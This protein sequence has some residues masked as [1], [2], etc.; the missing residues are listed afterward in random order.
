MDSDD[1]E[2]ARLVAAIDEA[3]RD[4][5]LLRASLSWRLTAPLRAV[6]DRLPRPPWL[7][8]RV[9][10]LAAARAARR[11]ERAGGE[12]ARHE[13]EL[14]YESRRI[15]ALRDRHA[16]RRRCF[17]VGNGPSIK[18]QDLTR[19]RGEVV[20]VT[21]TFILHEQLEAIAPT[22]YCVSDADF[23][24]EGAPELQARRLRLIADK[25]SGMTRFF[26][27]DARPR[28][29]PVLGGPRTYFLS[30]ASVSRAV[31][32]SGEISLDPSR[33]VHYADTVVIDFCLPLAFYMGFAEV[34][35]L[36][37]DTD[38]GLDRAPDYSQAYF[39]QP[40]AATFEPPRLHGVALDR[41]QWVDN[42]MR[43]YRVVKAA[44]EQ[45]GRHIYNATRGGKLEV[46]ERVVYEDVV[47]ARP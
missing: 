17:I 3:R 15:R 28:I 40:S 22:Y 38:Y 30:F 24:G 41:R 32:T 47:A 46:F 36:G 2:R 21:N 35:L 20:F 43:S 23:L 34:Y 13:A 10:A 5:A 11:V 42:V 26:P 9:A 8:D 31:W 44:F 1:A 45:H 7:E 6:Y 39:F 18:Q 14:A 37:C 33:S 12:H 4:V 19:L 29:R 27:H 25:T 16:R